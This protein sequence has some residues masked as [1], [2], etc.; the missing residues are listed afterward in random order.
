MRT[1][2]YRKVLVAAATAALLVPAGAATAAAAPASSGKAA[3]TRPSPEGNPLSRTAKAAGVCADARE[4]GSRGLIQ[5]NGETLASVKQ[6]YS[7]ECNENYGYVW[8]WAGFHDKGQPYDLTVGVHSYDDDA[9]HGKRVLKAT[10]KQ[11]VWSVG[12]DTVAQAT[13]GIGTLRP[14]G[15]PTTYQGLSSKRG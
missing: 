12:T 7:K 5:R 11:E 2:R 13:S 6:F 8:V 1:T 15:D 10:D 14:A 3:D 9:V 4:V